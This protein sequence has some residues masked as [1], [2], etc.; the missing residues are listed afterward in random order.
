M[1]SPKWDLPVSVRGDVRLPHSVAEA[2]FGTLDSSGF[3]KELNEATLGMKAP[4]FGKSRAQLNRPHMEELFTNGT[5]SLN[6][7]DDDAI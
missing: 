3:Q 5:L 4:N 1:L 6:F 2:I 7:G